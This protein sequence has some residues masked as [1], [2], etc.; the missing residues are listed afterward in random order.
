MSRPTSPCSRKA[1]PPATRRS[2]RCSPPP[3]W[4]T[5]VARAGGFAHGFTYLSNPLS[6][7][8]ALA[9]T[10]EVVDQGLIERAEKMGALLR[11][12]LEELAAETA[13]I[14][15]VRGKGLLMAVELVADKSS[16]RSL[17]IAV[18]APARFARV[19]RQHGITPYAR[20]TNAGKYGE[21][22]M[23]SPPLIVTEPQI[24]EIIDGLRATFRDFEDG[25]AREGLI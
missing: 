23:A 2:A 15:D 1:S 7:A 10:R 11:R 16:K 8:I 24:D 4:W 3:R 22:F 6:C 13:T 5:A 25:L 9:V 21:W 18:N 19:A 12:R 17:P 20:R 14:G